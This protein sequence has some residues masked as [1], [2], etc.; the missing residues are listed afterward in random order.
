MKV[1][2]LYL[3]A[4]RILNESCCFLFFRDLYLLYYERKEWLYVFIN[5][6]GNYICIVCGDSSDN[7]RYRR[8]CIS[9]DICRCD[10]LYCDNRIDY[11]ICWQKEIRR[12][13][14]SLMRV[15]FFFFY[16]KLKILYFPYSGDRNE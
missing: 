16:S 15:L 9:H 3:P 10:S 2:E 6:T 7:P 5:D 1:K 11:Q 13:G 14:Q 12:K 8:N 4:N